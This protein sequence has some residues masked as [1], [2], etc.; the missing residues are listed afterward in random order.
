MGQDMIIPE[1]CKKKTKH[2]EAANFGGIIIRR[3]ESKVD[4]HPICLYLLSFI[5]YAVRFLLFQYNLL[6]FPLFPV[7]ISNVSAYLFAERRKFVS[8]NIPDNDI[9]NLEVFV[10]NVIA[11]TLDHFPRSLGMK[12]NVVCDQWP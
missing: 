5:S 6:L 3:Q 9:V 2:S 11:H 4:V 1:S 8:H 12:Y 10:Y 7:G